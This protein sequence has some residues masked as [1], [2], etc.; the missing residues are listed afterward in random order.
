MIIIGITGAP[1]GGKSTVAAKLEDLGATWINADRIAHAQL[2]SPAIQASIVEYFGSDVVGG[3]GKIDRHRL[4]KRV[5]GDDD[6]GQQ[7]LRYLEALLHPPVRRVIS[8][9]IESARQSGRRVVVLDIPLLFEGDWAKVC[10]EIWFIDTSPEIQNEQ[11]RRRGWSRDDLELRQARQMSLAEKKE[12]STR[13]V[14]NHAAVDDLLKL[15]I[16]HWEKFV[17]PRVAD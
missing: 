13:A 11:A 9:Q 6:S 2:A 14:P 8:Q 7:G 10:D 12:R 3:D 4:G 17:L 16:E 1:A 15:V 5:F